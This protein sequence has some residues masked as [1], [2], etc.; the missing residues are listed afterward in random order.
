MLLCA[1]GFYHCSLH[2]SLCVS[3]NFMHFALVGV[4]LTLKP[5][6][7]HVSDL[8]TSFGR[9]RMTKHSWLKEVRKGETGQKMV[10]SE[11]ILNI[12]VKWEALL[13]A[14]VHISTYKKHISK[15]SLLFGF[16][17][18]EENSLT[19]IWVHPD[20]TWI[21]IT[22]LSPHVLSWTFGPLML[23]LPESCSYGHSEPMSIIL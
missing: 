17:I 2:G 7:F 19:M 9:L 6:M 13:N 8:L 15:S 22:P 12:S 21:S 18:C 1:W 4:W 3:H 16:F 20:Y 23:S 5:A 11:C 10:Q 14:T